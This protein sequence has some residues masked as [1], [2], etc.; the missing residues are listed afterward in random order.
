M[1]HKFEYTRLKFFSVQ[2]QFTN[3]IR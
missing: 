2:E 1:Q 3:V